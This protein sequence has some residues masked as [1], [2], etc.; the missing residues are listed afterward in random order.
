MNS[1]LEGWMPSAVK[2]LW[3]ALDQTVEH[4]RE[5]VGSN[6][7]KVKRGAFQVSQLCFHLP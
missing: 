4:K 6:L 3:D 1:R 2:C 7:R 5:G